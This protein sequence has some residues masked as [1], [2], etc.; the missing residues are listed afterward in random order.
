[1]ISAN[2]P[3]NLNNPIYLIDAPPTKLKLGDPLYKYFY[4]YKDDLELRS[5]LK[6][7]YDTL[8]YPDDLDTFMFGANH[9]FKFRACS[10]EYIHYKDK[11]KRKKYP[12]G[13]V[14]TTLTTFKNEIQ[15]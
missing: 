15:K 10:H 1:M 6:N 7:D 9:C 5:Y 13:Q 8:Y 14:L 2:H 12:Q 11:K 3:N 4:R